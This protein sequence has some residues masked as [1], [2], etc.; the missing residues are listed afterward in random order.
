[1]I[2][3]L[4]EKS[5]YKK[6]AADRTQRS[7]G[8]FYFFVFFAADLDSALAV[9]FFAGF[10]AAAG[11]VSALAAG[12]AVTAGLASALAAGFAVTAGLASFFAGALADAAGFFSA[13]FLG[14][15]VLDAFTFEVLIRNISC[16]ASSW[17]P[18][19]DS[20]PLFIASMGSILPDAMAIIVL[21]SVSK[22]TSLS[23]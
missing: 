20:F 7:F 18:S 13:D 19:M 23:L 2:P 6:T 14:A 12:F 16:L 17:F 1:M 11:L 5:I 22:I 10:A 4:S 8:L 3:G 9:V 21:P 15:A